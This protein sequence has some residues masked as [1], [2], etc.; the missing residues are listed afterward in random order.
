MTQ[1]LSS[2]RRIGSRSLWV[3]GR[4]SYA[5]VVERGR[6]QL[7]DASRGKVAERIFRIAEQS[8]VRESE[9][10]AHRQ[11][12]ATLGVVRIDKRRVRSSE[13]ADLP[14]A[15]RQ[16]DHEQED[17]QDDLGGDSLRCVCCLDPSLERRMIA[18]RQANEVRSARAK[19]KQELR[20]GKVRLEQVLATR[21]DYL[22]SAEVVDLLV[23][24]PKIGPVRAARLL[25]TARISQ[26]KTIGALS[27]RRRASLMELLSRLQLG[28][29]D[30]KQKTQDSQSAL[31]RMSSTSSGSNRYDAG[32]PVEALSAAHQ[33]P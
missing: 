11:Q 31:V 15:R 21:P 6:D 30:T 16:H 2:D 1:P 22:S 20:E 12:P 14:H 24:V 19:L 33:G 32:T 10:R 3:G 29:T 8:Q 18:L 13:L 5:D 28:Q 26:S 25:N 7:V 4:P 9:G 17:C 23:V 27:V